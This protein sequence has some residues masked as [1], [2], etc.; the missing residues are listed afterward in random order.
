MSEDR[1]GWPEKP[2]AAEVLEAVRRAAASALDL[3]PAR[4]P[5]EGSL[6]ALGLDSLS[7]AELA[8]AIESALGVEVP[9][10]SLLQGPSLVELA[11]QV[12][13]LLPAVPVLPALPAVPAVPAASAM[14]AMSASA[15]SAIERCALSWGQRAIWLLDRMAPGGNSAYVIAG[16]AR[17]GP[18]LDVAALRAAVSALVA[19]HGALRTTF[20]LDGEEPM[21]VV[22]PV[23]AFELVQEDA[24]AWSAAELEARMVEEAHRPFHLARGPLLRVAVWRRQGEHVVVLAVHHIVADFRS[25]GV[26][27]VELGA[28][29]GG[30]PLPPPAGTASHAGHVRR[31]AE[32]LRGERGESLRAYWRAVLPPDAPPLELPA[33][34]PRPPLQTFR[35]DA[36]N[37]R[38]GPTAAAATLAV[39]AAAGTTPFMTLL[40]AYLVLLHRHSGQ[41]RLLVG[42]PTAGRGAPALAGVVGYFVNPVVMRG[43]LAGDP[44][45]PALLARVREAAIGAY[46]HQ[47]YPFALLAEQLGTRRDASRSPVFQTMFTLYREAR[48]SERGL[49]G[50]ALGEAGSRLDLG[51]LRLESVRLP[52]R[53]AQLDL[54]LLMAEMDGGLAA[55]LQ[56][57]SD[58]F[59]ATTATR[60]LG[61]L[62]NLLAALAN[63]ASHA[64]SVAGVAGS[65]VMDAVPISALPLL[66]RAESHQLTAEWNDTVAAWVSPCA[67]GVGPRGAVRSAPAE[68]IHELFERQA[69]R[70]PGAAAVAGQGSSLT[71]GELE[72]RANRLARYLWRLGVGPEARVG[73]CVGR[74]PDMVVALLAILKAG[75][76]YV[77]LDPSHPAARLAS[78][79]DDGAAEVLVTEERW[80]ERLG[81]AAAS[82]GRYVVCLDRESEWIAAEDAA[83][84]GPD[85]PGARGAGGAGAESL[86]YLIYTSGSTGRPKGV[87]VPHRAVV[88]FLRSMALRPGLGA[89]D[90]MT[91]LTTLSFDIAGLEIW[92]PLAVGGRV[93]MVDHDEGTD[94]RRLAARLAAAGVTAMQA[95]PPTWRLLLEAGWRARGPFKALCGGEALPR[96]LA[97]ELL[98]AGAELWNMYGPTETAIWSATRPVGGAAG[99]GVVGLGRPIANTRLVVVDR[100]FGPAPLGVSGELLIG[101]AGVARGYWGRPELTA[102]RFLPDPWS[103]EPG[104]RLY[105]TGDLVRRLPDG[106]LEFLGRIDQQVKVRGHRIELGEIESA[107]LRHPA[108]GQA[109]VTVRGEGAGRRLLAYLVVRREAPAAAPAALRDFVRQA[110][111]EYMVPA[112]YAWLDRLPLGPSG[113]V[114]RNALPAPGRLPSPP[115]PAA[116]FAAGAAGPVGTEGPS[117]GHIAPRTPAEELAAA[118]WAEVLGLDAAAVSVDDDFFRLGGHSLLAVRLAGR[119]RDLLGIELALPRLLQ[120]SRLEDLAR[121]LESGGRAGWPPAAAIA[122][123]PRTPGT[124]WESA[125]SFA[126]ERLWFL[127]RLD[128]GSAAYNEARALRLTG[129]LEVAA[130]AASLGEIRAR[131]EVLRTR[132][133]AHPDGRVAALA[134]AP[135]STPL[136]LPV[137]DLSALPPPRGERVAASLVTEEARRPF[138][139]AADPLLRAALLR[140]ARDA[141]GEAR[142]VLLLNLHHTVSDGGSL[143]VLARE[144]SIF[145]TAGLGGGQPAPGALPAL[146]IQYADFAHWQREWASGPHLAAELDWWREQLG[147]RRGEPPRLDLPLDRPR[148]AAASGRGARRAMHLPA[149]LAGA[150]SGVAQRHGVTLFMAL[151]AA[152]DTLLYRYTGESDV[153]VGTPVASRDRPEV[154]G[155]IGLFVNTLV[156]RLDLA[157]DPTAAELLARVRQTALAAYAHQD[158]P[159]DKL[160]GELAPRRGVAE[161]PFFQVF[162]ALQ[163]APPALALPG[164]A[165]EYLDPDSGAAKFDLALAFH[166]TAAGGLAG[167]WTWR[168]DLFDAA[169]VARIGGHWRNLLEALAGSAVPGAEAAPGAAEAPPGLA[170][171]SG[172]RLS[173]LPLLAA[174]ERHQLLRE[175]NATAALAAGAGDLVHVPIER[176]AAA[177]PAAAALAA[178]LPE[179]DAGGSRRASGWRTLTYGELEERASRLAH[180]LRRLGVGPEQV[181]GVCGEASFA[182]VTGLL[183]I[184]K[185]GGAYLP[186]DPS[187]PRERLAR[188]VADSGAR[189]V[190]AEDGLAGLAE[191]LPAAT[192][193]LPLADAPAWGGAGAVVGE[194]GAAGAGAGAGECAGRAVSPHPGNAAYVLYTS[195][196]TGTPKGVVVPHGAVANR[197]R[198]Q[199]AADLVP[200]ARVLQRTRLAFD[201]SVVELFAPLWAGATV[202]LTDA[203][204]RHDPAYL[205][206]VAAEQGVT[207]LNAPPALL[208]A[209]LAEED[210]HR[211]RSVRRVVTGGDRVPGDLPQRFFAAFGMQAAGGNG[212]PRLFSRYGP[213]EATVSVSEWE[214]LPPV[215]GAGPPPLLPPLV[216]LGRPIAGS[217]FHVLDRRYLAGETGGACRVSQELPVGAAGELCIAGSCLARGYL[218]RPDLT[219][220]VFVPDP[221]A[222]R[223][224][225]AGG[226]LYRTGDL[227]RYRPDGALEFLGRLDQQVKIRGFRIEL[228]EIEAALAAH[229]AVHMAAAAVWQGPGGERRLVAFAVAEPAPGPGPA[230]AELRAFLQARLPEPMVPTDVLLVAALPLSVHGK[231]DR[232]ALAALAEAHAGARRAAPADPA[233]TARLS[234]LEELVAGLWSQLLGVGQVGAADN[235][236]NL[237]GHS[238]L[239]TQVVS[240]VRAELG[241]ELPLRAVFEHPTVAGL[242]AELERLRRGVAAPPILPVSRQGELPLSFAQQRLWFLDQLEP[243]SSA[244]NLP[245]ALRLEG[246]LGGRQVALLRR[247]LLAVVRRH[248]ALRTRFAAT[249]RGPV[250]EVMAAPAAAAGWALPL[251]CLDGLPAGSRRGEALRLAAAE[252]RRPFLLSVAPLLRVTLVRLAPGDHL[253]LG[254]LHHIV[255]D[256]WS[257]GILLREVSAFYRAFAGR[258]EV[259]AREGGLPEVSPTEASPTEASAPGLSELPIQYADFA[260]WQRAWLRGEA[261]ETQLAYWRDQLAGAPGRLDLPVDRPRPA[262]PSRRGGSVPVRLPGE[263]S[264]Q[265]VALSRSQ[266]A[267][268]FMAL[269]AAFALLLGRSANQQDVTLGTP[270]ANRNRREIED[271]IGCFVN[272]LVLRIGLG[273]A[274]SFH[275]LLRRVREV[276]L[277]AYSHQDLPFERLVDLVEDAVPGRDQLASPLV[278]VMFVLQSAGGEALDLPGL[279]YSAVELPA[280]TAKFDLTLDLA[281]KEGGFAGSFEFDRDL[282]DAATVRRHARRLETLLAA[283]VLHPEEPVAELPLLAASERHQLLREWSSGESA[284]RGEREGATLAELFEEQVR[285]APGAPAVTCEGK[286]LTYSE[287][288]RRANQLAHRL[289][290]LGV[291]ADERVG[292]CVE[293]SLDLVVGVL[294]IVK[295]GGAYVPLD[296]SYPRERQA[297]LA[298]DAGARVV[299]GTSAPPA[300]RIAVRLD[301]G[302]ADLARQPAENLPRLASSAHLA[303]VIHTSG[304][305]GRP[306]GVLVSHDNVARLF[307][308][309]WPTFRFGPDDV[310]TLFHSYAFDFSVWELWGAL[311]Y[312]GRLV[313]V[314]YAVSRTPEAW[315]ELLAG[316][317][318]TVLNQTPSAFAQLQRADEESAA[319]GGLAALRL[320]IFGGEAL[321]PFRLASWFRRYGDRRPLLVNM[322]G[323]TETTVH[324]TW[325]PLAAA[326]AQAGRGSVIGRAIADLSA[327]VLDGALQPAPIGVAG[328]LF[329]GGAGLA[330]GY[331]GRPELT[332]E[333]FVP[334]PFAAALPGARLYRTGDLARV[335]PDGSLEYLGRLD[336]QVKIRGF[337][338]EPQEIQAALAADPRVQETLVLARKEEGGARRLVAYVVP[339]PGA[340]PA[341]HELRDRLAAELPDY[342]VP[343]A[344][345]LLAALPLTAHGKV[346]R[347]ALLELAAVRREESRD[348][349]PPRNDS[350]GA[351][352]EIWEQVLGLDR[353]GIDDRFFSI[354]GDSILSLRLRSLAAERGLHFTLPQLFEHQTVRELACRLGS[355]QQD[356]AAPPAPFAL[357]SPADRAALPA[358]LD[359]AYPLT[360]LQTGMLFH[361]AWSADSTLYHNVSS[362]RLAGVFDEEALR[363]AIERLLARHATLRTSFDLGSYGVPLQLIH[364]RVDLPLAVEDLCA[365]PAAEQERRLAAAFAAE[366][367]CKFDG[368]AAPLLRFRVQRL[369]AEVF[370]LT[371]A[372]HHAILDGWSVA[373]MMAELFQLYRRQRRADLPAPALAP[374][375]A[376]FRDFVAL[377][378]SA[379]AGEA[380]DE[381]RRFWARRLAGAPHPQLPARLPAAPAPEAPETPENARGAPATPP[382][383]D[384]SVDLGTDRTRALT[385]LAA[386]SGVALRSVLLAAHCR[387]LATITGEADLV[388][389]LVVNGRP[390]TRDGERVL[391]LFL[392]TLPLRLR[393]APG[394]WLDL[395][396]RTA[397]AEREILPYRRFPMAEVR[398][399]AGGALF[400][401]GFNFTHFH[402]LHGLEDS[403]IQVL[404]GIAVGDI[405]LP[406]ATDFSLDAASSRLTL[407]L[408]FAEGRFA[409]WQVERIAGR[410]TAALDA[411]I[412]CPEGRHEEAPLTTPAE[413]QQLLREWNDTRAATPGLALHELFDLQAAA[414]PDAVAVV[415][416]GTALTYGELRRRADHLARHLRSLG[417]GPEERVGLLV[418]RSPQMIVALLA[419]LESGAAYV[420]MDP[421]APVGRLAHVLEDCGARLLVTRAALARGWGAAKAVGRAAVVD[422]DA[423]PPDRGLD[424]GAPPAGDSG[425]DRLAYVIYTS[426]S[427]GVPKGV[428]VSHGAV[429]NYAAGVARSFGLRPTDRGLQFAPLSFDTSVEEI[430]AMLLAGASLALRD[431]EMLASPRRFLE[432]LGD[433]GVTMAMLPTAYWHE[434]AAAIVDPEVRPPA[435]LRVIY[436]GGEKA[437]R[438]HVE[439]WLA[440]GF[441][442]VELVN[443]YGPTEATV[444][445]A[446]ARLG[447]GDRRDGGTGRDGREVP[448]GRPVANARIYL[449]DGDLMPAPA[450]TVG[451]VFV[452]GTGVARGYQG[453]P[454]LTAA[455]FV[456]DPWSGAPGARMYRT[457]DLAAHLADGRLE[458]RGRGDDQVKIRGFRVEPGEIELAL[459]RHPA[460]RQAVVAAR[461]DARGD[462]FLAA[463]VVAGEGA[464]PAPAELKRFL[465]E[466]LPAYMV[467]AAFVLLDRLP[468]NTNDKIDRQALPAPVPGR[469]D[470]GRDYLAPRDPLELQ[471]VG[472]WEELLGIFPIGA[473]DDFFELGGH[474]LLAVQLIA[475][476][477][478]TF[479]RCLPTAAVLQHPTIEGLAGLL[480]EGAVPARR[481][482][483]VEMTTNGTKALFCVHPIGGDVLCYAHL[484]R[485]LAG[486]RAVH[487][488][489]VPDRD[490]EAPWATIEEMARHYVGCLR[491]T[492]PAGPYA[493]A[494]WSMG[495]VVAFEM[496]RQLESAGAE[497]ELLALIDATAP[498]GDAHRDD[499]GGGARVARFAGDLAHLL[500]LDLAATSIDLT[501]LT[502]PEALAALP[503]EAERLGA[504]LGLDAAELAR[505]FAIYEANDHLLERYTGGACAVPLTLFKAVGS[506]AADTV[507]APAASGTPAAAPDLGWSALATG[508][509]EVLEVSGDHYSLLEEPQ[510]HL[511]A[512]HLRQ[513]LVS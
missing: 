432:A 175:W 267:T 83:P 313:V 275:S 19:R 28:L 474:S 446:N 15:P 373:S 7:A 209:L 337:R 475:R 335:L 90:V 3:D 167:T 89:A 435:G 388:T 38:L 180:H 150:L 181:V 2:A 496:A 120:L 88:N 79:L 236:F 224:G 138:D 162:F 249:P 128:P 256:G 367:R 283:V 510:V 34:R 82:S 339:R 426:G 366:R 37:L 270:I 318:V 230:P 276:A 210:L 495:G 194:S 441:A 356:L 232:R 332:A 406:L 187:L 71:Y 225:E 65:G 123:L 490:G 329:I 423:L 117:A 418:E 341:V 445:C 131:H 186:L 9:M 325:R 68:R 212:A 234:P 52:R 449:L 237:G 505:R 336:H 91:A 402:V 257:I 357:L 109:V 198:F 308:A 324:V 215:A 258:Q 274:P 348:Y 74:S 213:T 202:V 77:P 280:Q 372:L 61:Q 75:G 310:W 365:L 484:A 312:G 456:P 279:A 94:G 361:S 161:T 404:G 379:L 54:A 8:G 486:E 53:A 293:R 375:A 278:Q 199:L 478:R 73:L 450:G 459:C 392:N 393:V 23:A 507:S 214:C 29:Y 467:P 32:R 438:E 363:G 140:L 297:F 286:G 127:D 233:A 102:E 191:R 349:Q 205:A 238:L 36:R 156:L 430:F 381:A 159:F 57:N 434:L 223:S 80:L 334:D 106:D 294:G 222:A 412:A 84:L 345:V 408:Q 245:R 502:I 323:I 1:G 165:V 480:R 498:R 300:G 472:I 471:L 6:V 263:L 353:V 360:A 501:L 284:N 248:E 69:A 119:L 513:R 135:S 428:M 10:V 460:V 155:L 221:Y 176:Q 269:A 383:R 18:D 56:F 48:E 343:A 477:Q 124:E 184:L 271:L 265:V 4:L 134:G 377:E 100:Q 266:G 315:R 403:E 208:A 114:D 24:A 469:Q 125:L 247:A 218:G 78:I 242:A 358:G 494:G 142:H 103:A 400:E 352:V 5:D 413:R 487:G 86:A 328:E 364:A 368:S 289:R 354:G 479:D 512:A 458:F 384:L 63:D 153:A 104:A 338:I 509:I 211:A 389:G 390:E 387:M 185:A 410:Y 292:L 288:N 164:L 173:E 506:I 101:G 457:G 116:M 468:L 226:R 369:A 503:A 133:A 440:R 350:E 451:T 148:P 204:Q 309:T 112:D 346:D 326:D 319:P 466:R 465:R 401:T 298:A 305:T 207:N 476:V 59:D 437:R 485:H 370:Q 331:L 311:L 399:A 177:R 220:A 407:N 170:A 442:G 255:A 229:P 452:A 16:A 307:A 483:L 439:R 219:A 200:G 296:P 105:R 448:I 111:P 41:E 122:R 97:A 411:M 422:L 51:G 85:G 285:R 417:A 206:A 58:L 147:G 395:V 136:A 21:Q 261:L 196:S 67:N 488:L 40:A 227:A 216:P 62:A 50:F 251:V 351:L 25:L 342:M 415:T 320:V 22:H 264:R 394:S 243:G 421:D 463:W 169:T 431:E 197:L 139:L 64:A 46:A 427:S 33:D 420:P 398:R 453:R 182:L 92:L 14:P 290:E 385:R 260:C 42:T 287:L 44:S 143:E 157:G 228:G 254:T 189:L 492:Q 144:L 231:L 113:K 330:R 235:F 98:A 26:L 322:Y 118:L 239:A 425:T 304:S 508:P 344:F 493:L 172:R 376:A 396:R 511:V 429:V 154:Q 481:R 461:E 489:Q 12:A 244:Y 203:A 72:S 241:V 262:V 27:L 473:R 301:A 295:A 497:V 303:Y 447:A 11:E 359:D 433:L 306:K 464:R 253:L 299:V 416:R 95:T 115:A 174:A 340:A 146:P 281:A 443:G 87:G 35:G 121:E 240:R 321:E 66:S 391:G 149:A 110:L 246:A 482:A 190:L 166:R 183:A 145:Y 163:P 316:E 268:P 500:A 259:G 158:V 130:L 409:A 252:A 160:V 31:E 195:G 151:L 49:G 70:R 362:F 99:G 277:G 152:F 192:R 137:I 414:R 108:V 96:E 273:G 132:F 424:G 454:D 178:A 250:Q 81:G 302:A 193:V 374:P 382:V 93:E 55:S 355:R 60:M 39:G 291:G 378:R 43:D 20:E 107:L 499:L 188:M 45:F 314:P 126:Q 405:E 491:E 397:E 327:H 282:F 436:I 333:R 217:R 30:R 317:R 47:D 76:A 201:V 13:D 129:R 419:I 380:G 17:T 272:T 455:S 179:H 168:S 444:V 141:A 386:S 504:P 171:G 470:L 371:W 347:Q 462:V